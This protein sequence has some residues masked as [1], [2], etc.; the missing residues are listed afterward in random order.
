MKNEWISVKERLP[1]LL[2]QFLVH[3]KKPSLHLS[4]Y[5]VLTFG[6]DIGRFAERHEYVTHWMPIPE[7]PDGAE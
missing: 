7:A 4:Y 2:R 5:D 1:T 6:P 3:I